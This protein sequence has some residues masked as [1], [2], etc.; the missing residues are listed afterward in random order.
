MGKKRIKDDYEKW[1]RAK[2][3]DEV[4]AIEASDRPA[5]VKE[6]LLKIRRDVARMNEVLDNAGLLPKNLGEHRG[7]NVAS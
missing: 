3:D 5:M 6:Y 2:L 1:D 4:E 7:A